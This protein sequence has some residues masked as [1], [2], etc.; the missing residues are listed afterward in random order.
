MLQEANHMAMLQSEYTILLYQ[1][2]NQVNIFFFLVLDMHKEYIDIDIDIEH[3][4]I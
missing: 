1:D 2:I 3:I 4:D